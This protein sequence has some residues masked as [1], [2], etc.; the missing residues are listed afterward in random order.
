MERN[1]FYSKRRLRYF[2]LMQRVG[3]VG[4]DLNEPATERHLWLPV[5]CQ[6]LGRSAGIG[7][8][9]FCNHYNKRLDQAGVTMGCGI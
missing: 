1:L 8:P 3:S 7:K 9:S 6:V 5:E 2:N 4:I